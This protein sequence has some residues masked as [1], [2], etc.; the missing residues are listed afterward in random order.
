MVEALSVLVFKWQVPADQTV[1]DNSSTP[2][3]CFLS[4]IFEAFDKFR[5]SV[6]RRPTCCDKLFVGLVSV[7]KTKINDF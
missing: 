6:A 2:K 5:G 7:A 3:I 4:V 1:K